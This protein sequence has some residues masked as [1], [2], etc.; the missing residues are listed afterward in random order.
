M[1]QKHLLIVEDNDILSKTLQRYL[2]GLGLKVTTIRTVAGAQDLLTNH[3]FDA[4]LVDIYLPD[5]CGLDLV[6]LLPDSS[7]PVV[8]MT[9]EA[10]WSHRKQAC[11]AGVAAFLEKP[12]PLN[13]LKRTLKCVLVGHR[14]LPNCSQLPCMSISPLTTQP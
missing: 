10:P 4:L 9:A 7:I 6:R 14:C 8:A 13:T 12:F 3:S 11:D 5:A 2:V 1:Q